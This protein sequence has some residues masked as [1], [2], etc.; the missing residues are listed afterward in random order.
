MNPNT[1]LKP[2]I[3]HLEANI[4]RGLFCKGCTYLEDDEIE[5]MG[6]TC[7]PRLCKLL[8]EYVP[9]NKICGINE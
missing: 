9:N 7:K 3:E 1:E 4:P 6:A 5:L 8:D 2:M